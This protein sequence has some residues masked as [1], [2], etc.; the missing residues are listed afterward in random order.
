MEFV[1]SAAN[2]LDVVEE[3]VSANGW[4]FDRATSQ[5]LYAEMTGDWCGYRLCFTWTAEMHVLHVACTF[6]MKVPATR[7]TEVNSLLAL[8]NER[9]WLGHFEVDSDDG[10]PAFR[11]AIL[12]RGMSGPRVE[13]LEDLV[14][15]AVTTS[16]RFYPA[17][18]YVIWGGHGAEESIAAAVLETVGEA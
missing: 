13:Q 3:I 6:D 4:P 7:R 16:E 17:F 9:L 11:H 18:Q 10:V 2:P 1:E 12:L 8:A 15:I 14:D 5:E